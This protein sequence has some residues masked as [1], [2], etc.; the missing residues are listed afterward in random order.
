MHS[1]FNQIKNMFTAMHFAE[2]G[3][4]DSVKQILL[5]NPCTSEEEESTEATGQHPAIP[6]F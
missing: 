3:D 4:L 2:E 1:I 6:A 5:E